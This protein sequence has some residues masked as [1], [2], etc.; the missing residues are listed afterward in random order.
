MG[1]YFFNF[2]SCEPLNKKVLVPDRK[3]YYKTT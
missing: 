1:I 3:Q 2:V